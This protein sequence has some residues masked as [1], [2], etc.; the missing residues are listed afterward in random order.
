M[1]H[2]IQFINL[3]AN[4]AHSVVSCFEGLSLN[5]QASVIRFALSPLIEYLFKRLYPWYERWYDTRHD[6]EID[7]YQRDN[8]KEQHH[9]HIMLFF[10]IIVRLVLI[11]FKS[12]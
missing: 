4:S 9:Y 3:V 12:L 11:V 5:Q 6:S 1:I 8:K 7:E 2:F 10:D